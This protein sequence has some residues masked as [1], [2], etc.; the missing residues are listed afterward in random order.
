MSHDD[1]DFNQDLVENKLY[2]GA[3][4]DENSEVLTMLKK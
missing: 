4:L 3:Y 1:F 2:K